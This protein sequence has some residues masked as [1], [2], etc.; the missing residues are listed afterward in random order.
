MAI[1]DNTAEWIAYEISADKTDFDGYWE[2]NE[3][4]N[5]GNI[6]YR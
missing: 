6:R 3:E 2:A 5:V 4:V 1:L